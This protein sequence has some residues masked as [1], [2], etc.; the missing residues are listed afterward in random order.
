MP[1]PSNRGRLACTRLA[2][3]RSGAAQQV[4]QAFLIREKRVVSVL[5]F[6]DPERRVGAG[7]LELAVELDLQRPRKQHVAGHADDERFGGHLFERL[8]QRLSVGGNRSP[9]DRFAQEQEGLDRKTLGEAAAVMLEVSGHRRLVESRHQPAEADVELAAAAIGEHADLPRPPHAG[10]D[11]AVAQAIAHQLA[12]QVPRRR[13]PAVGPQARRDRDQLRAAFGITHREGRPDHPAEACADEGDRR[14][15]SR[16]PRATP[17]S[18]RRVRAP[19][20]PELAPRRRRS[21]ARSSRCR[22]STGQ[23]TVWRDGVDQIGREERRPPGL[24]HFAGRRIVVAQGKRRRR[25]AADDDEHG[26]RAEL[27]PVRPAAQRHVLK[28]VALDGHG[29]H[30]RRSGGGATWW[31]QLTSASG[32]RAPSN[33]HT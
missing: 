12:L 19:K 18:D 32:W 9:I 15:R 26:G 8:P 31:L 29:R 25:D 33:P 10:R 24:P 16:S 20:S 21:R 4:G 14:R 3:E 1:T 11:V 23:S 13:A 2:T 17:P 5:R 28:L 30:G 27:R 7:R 6:K 22:A